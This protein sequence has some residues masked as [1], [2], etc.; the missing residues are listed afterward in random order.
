MTISGYIISIPYC[1]SVRWMCLLVRWWIEDTYMPTLTF[2]PTNINMCAKLPYCLFWNECSL[3]EMH[4][5]LEDLVQMLQFQGNQSQFICG[6]RTFAKDV[7]IDKRKVNNFEDCWKIG[8]LL[9]DRCQV[10]YKLDCG[11]RGGKSL[12]TL[13][14]P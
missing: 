1:F 6:K 5:V 7:R 9:A 14:E 10:C 8:K 3:Q 2:T 4:E 12:N 11:G 13:L